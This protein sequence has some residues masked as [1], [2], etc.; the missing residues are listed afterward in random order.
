MR[1]QLPCVCVVPPEGGGG[2]SIKFFIGRIRPGGLVFIFVKVINFYFSFSSTESR[3]LTCSSRYFPLTLSISIRCLF[4]AL[5]AMK[6]PAGNKEDVIF[7]LTSTA[8]GKNFIREEK[9]AVTL[10]A[11]LFSYQGLHQFIH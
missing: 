4:T 8:S 1:C 3:F 6:I 5:A 7:P 2:D 11:S 10:P 9:N